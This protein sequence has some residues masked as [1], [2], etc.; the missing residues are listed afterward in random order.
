MGLYVKKDASTWVPATSIYVK[1]STSLW[2][3]VKKIYVKTAAG[4]W[5]VILA[6]GWVHIQIFPLN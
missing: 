2:Q 1:A 4:V 3:I 5:N 6:K